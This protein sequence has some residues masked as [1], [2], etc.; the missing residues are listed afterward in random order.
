[1]LSPK[2]K[3]IRYSVSLS[4]ADSSSTCTGPVSGWKKT[5][6]DGRNVLKILFIKNYEFYV[7]SNSCAELYL[8]SSM[9]RGMQG[10]SSG[11]CKVC[12]QLCIHFLW[13]STLLGLKHITPSINV[14]MHA[15]T[16][17]RRAAHTTCRQIHTNIK[18]FQYKLLNEWHSYPVVCNRL[19]ICW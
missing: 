2:L 7:E 8:N 5:H 19:E 17:R 13:V 16:S 14:A 11:F 15:F 6:G 1:M 10:V 12:V 4:P 9:T 3:A 18:Y